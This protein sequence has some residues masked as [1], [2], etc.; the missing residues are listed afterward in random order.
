[1]HKMLVVL[2][3]AAVLVLALSV[4]A[5]A[6][7]GP[8]HQ[9]PSSVTFWTQYLEGPQPVSDLGLG[10]E[11]G[12]I[13]RLGR[14]IVPFNKAVAADLEFKNYGGLVAVLAQQDKATP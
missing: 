13:N 14:D 2:I 10:A 3:V 7:P 5:M 8:S 12:M 6:A 11:D 4:P 1:M 9:Y